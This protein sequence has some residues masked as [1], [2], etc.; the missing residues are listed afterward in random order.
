M[1]RLDAQMDKAREKEMDDYF[2]A[3][4]EDDAFTYECCYCGEEEIPHENMADVLSDTEQ[5][6]CH[7][8]AEVTEHAEDW[9][10]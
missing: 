6:I 10:L 3:G 7:E 2:E 5:G 8:C 9:G 4:Y 1:S